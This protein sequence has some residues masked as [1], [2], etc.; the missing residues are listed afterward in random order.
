MDVCGV[1][2][3][4]HGCKLARGHSGTHICECCTC[5]I[6]RHDGVHAPFLED[7]ITL[8]VAQAPYY[9]SITEFYED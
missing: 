6:G 8:C 4:S 9:G 1:Y 5:P 3:G 2:W 7:G